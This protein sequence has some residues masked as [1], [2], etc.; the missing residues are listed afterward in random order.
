MKIDTL[1]KHNSGHETLIYI[2]YVCLCCINIAVDCTF[3]LS[4][5]WKGKIEAFFMHFIWLP[6]WF[7]VASIKLGNVEFRSVFGKHSWASMPVDHL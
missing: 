6:W 5:I 1:P 4:K 2:S 7:I 3:R